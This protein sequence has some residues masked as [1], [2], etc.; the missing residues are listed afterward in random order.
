MNNFQKDKSITQV[1]IEVVYE[2]IFNAKRVDPLAERAFLLWSFYI[3][4]N[5]MS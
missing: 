2:D 5:H 1:L 4:V 3:I